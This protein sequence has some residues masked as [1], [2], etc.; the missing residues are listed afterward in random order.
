M[1]LARFFLGQ[2][3]ATHASD[4]YE[5]RTPGSDRV[6]ADLSDDQMRARPGQGINSLVWLLWHM[7]RTEDVAVNLVVAARAQVFDDGWARRMNV[8]RCDMGT[9]M[10]ADEVAELTGR[11]AVAA[12]RAYRSAVGRRTREV[13]RGL[14]PEAW[15]ETLGLEDTTR[16]AGVEAFGPNDDWIDG[17]GH[18]PWQGL[19][20]GDQLGNTAIRHNTAHVGEAVTIR[21]LAGFGLGI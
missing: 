13:V 19:T 2:H 17:V 15:D 8:A 5:G 6:F 20:R 10:T 14:R 16:A 18:R 3:A 4:V 7:A 21:G 11:A 9:G 12:V 1:D